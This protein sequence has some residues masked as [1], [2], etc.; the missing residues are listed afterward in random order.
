MRNAVNN[1]FT[2]GF[3]DA[4]VWV[5]RT[6]E[7]AVVE[8]M[9]RRAALGTRQAPRL[10]EQER[11]YGKT[12]L[13]S[14][15]ADAAAG[16]VPGTVV[17]RVTAVEGEA[18]LAAFALRLTQAAATLDGTGERLAV[19]IAQTLASVRQIRIAGVLDVTMDHEGKDMPASI[20]L[21]RALTD[22]AAR[23]RTA[24][25]TVA[26][27]IDE[28]QAIDAESRRAVFT[29][30][31]ETERPD[32]DGLLPPF[33]WL[34]AGLPGTRGKFK[35]HRVT[36]GERCRDLPLVGLDSE[37]VRATL[38]RFGEFNDAGVAF[39]PDAIE[40]LID[41]CSGHPH[42]F[43]LIGEGA[44]DAT[45]DTRTITVD[46]VAAGVG[47]SAAERLRIAAARL[48]GLDSGETG[49]A[50]AMAGLASDDRT[51]T[52][53]CR[54]YRADPAATAAQCGSTADRLL[55]K[56]IIRR[57]GGDLVFALPGIEELLARD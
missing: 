11:G 9:V 3:G 38:L 54:A 4:G 50:R 35:A 48:D 32:T 40:A 36:F 55:R 46:D 20:A 5:D 44:W 19:R 6:A 33:A 8:A 16:W 41:A 42:V 26:F 28:A 39:A 47:S 10:I 49:W 27:L 37:A 1:P 21:G 56:G 52:K 14:A 18:F 43:Q 7:L 53:I 2:P 24:G 30:V 22:L 12:S 31:Q 15:V 17:V 34:L 13:L 29:A 57:S 25:V 51:L 45:A 23:A